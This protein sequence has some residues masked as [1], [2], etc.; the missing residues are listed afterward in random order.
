V[1]DV[2]RALSD[3]RRRQL[4]DA[5]RDHD[6]QTLLELERCLPDLTRHGVMRHLRVLEGARLVTTRKEGRHKFHYLN[7][8]PIRLVHDRW[9]SNYEVRIAATLTGIKAQ[10][11]AT[12]MDGQTRRY[13]IYIQ[14]TPAQL[15]RAITDPELSQK[16]WYGSL[17]KSDWRPGSRW[18]SESPDGLVYLDGEILEA[19]PPR[20]LV[21]TF[22]VVHEEAA[23]KD[24]PS[25]LTWEIEQMGPACR[26]VVTHDRLQDA[27]AAYVDGGMDYVLSGLKTVLET[28]RPLVL[29]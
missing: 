19:D 14:T 6:G 12:E 11:E 22:H 3:P 1:D 28:G 17:L 7:P 8:V 10:L 29:A 25:R 15:W 18:T 4:L 21:E 13:E 9:I 26:L 16:Y 20:R 27:T 5:L 24:Q 2:F 23:A